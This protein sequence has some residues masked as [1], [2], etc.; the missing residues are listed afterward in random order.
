MMVGT[1]DYIAPEQ[2]QGGAVDARAD[3]YALGC[4][5]YQALTGQVPFPR[6]TEPAKMWAHMSEP[7][8]R[9]A[10]VAPE[11]PAQFDEVITR[12]MA[13]QPDDRYLS[14]GDLGRAAQAAAEGQLA[15]PR[16]AQRGDRRRRAHRPGAGAV[17]ATAGQAPPD[18]AGATVMGEAAAPTGAPNVPPTGPAARSRRLEPCGRAARAG[19][20]PGPA[21]RLAA[22][23]HRRARPRRVRRAA[24]R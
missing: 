9:A 19:R 15:D 4:V 24:C 12:A 5:L 13:K 3:V 23:P 14:A 8:P 21:R 1:L 18:P 17:P 11:L 10:A 7:P 20:A 2:L 22:A 16:R 6:D